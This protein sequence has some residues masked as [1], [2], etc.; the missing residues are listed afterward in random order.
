M[1]LSFIKWYYT[2]CSFL[3]LTFLMTSWLNNKSLS[4]L[5]SQLYDYSHYNPPAGQETWVQ[6]L[7]W[8]DPLNKEMATHSSIFAWGIPWTEEPG[9]L[10]SIGSRRVRHDW[11]TYL[12]SMI[13]FLPVPVMWVVHIEF[14]VL[15]FLLFGDLT[16]W[17]EHFQH[18]YRIIVFIL[19]Y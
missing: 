1:V 8:E 2:I 3:W 11:A 12:N 19:Y 15:P 17:R 14:E 6:S 4:S 10:Q 16:F 9:G 7:G 18:Y 13:Y 5:E